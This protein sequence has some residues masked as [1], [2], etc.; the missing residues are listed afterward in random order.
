M[1]LMD[2]LLYLMDRLPLKALTWQLNCNGV[3]G[4]GRWNAV[5]SPEGFILDASRNESYLRLTLYRGSN[6]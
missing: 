1:Y 4:Q 6:P 3:M 5:E 2:R